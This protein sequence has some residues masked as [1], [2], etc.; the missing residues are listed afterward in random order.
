[1]QSEKIDDALWIALR[2]LEERA[3]LAD[4]LAERAKQQ[5]TGLTAERFRGQAA[6][7]RRR[8]AQVRKVLKQG[9]VDAAPDDEITAGSG[10]G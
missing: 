9:Q 1:M 5:R 6:E 8:A 3:S 10:P 4:R 7:I 2:A